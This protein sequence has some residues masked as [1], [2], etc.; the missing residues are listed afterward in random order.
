MSAQV[1]AF[2]AKQPVKMFEQAPVLVGEFTPFERYVQ[3]LTFE[4]KEKEARALRA[5]AK[6]AEQTKWAKLRLAEQVELVLV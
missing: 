1:L 5:A 3:Q 4:S 6:L 2:P